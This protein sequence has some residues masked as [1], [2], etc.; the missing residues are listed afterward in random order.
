M[1]LGDIVLHVWC[2]AVRQ[3]DRGKLRYTPT[4]T[5][6]QKKVLQS[7]TTVLA[8]GWHNGKRRLFHNTTQGNVKRCKRKCNQSVSNV[9]SM[10]RVHCGYIVHVFGIHL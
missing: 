8:L 3:F 10:H 1:H 7:V 4:S 9:I 2:G 5:K 6:V